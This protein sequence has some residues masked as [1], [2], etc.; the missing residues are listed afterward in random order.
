[1]LKQLTDLWMDSWESLSDKD[2][3]KGRQGKR[4]GDKE[5]KRGKM[6]IEEM[7]GKLSP[8]L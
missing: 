8:P 7:I 4:R 3:R 1:M 5:E 6:G 2:K